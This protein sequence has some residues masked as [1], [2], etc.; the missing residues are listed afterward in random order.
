[1][2]SAGV[3]MSIFDVAFLGT[4]LTAGTGTANAGGVAKPGGLWQPELMRALLP[5]RSS[6]LRYYNFGIPGGTSVDGLAL[7]PKVAGLRP[8]VAVIEFCVNDAATAKSVSLAQS[9]AN[10]E[11]IIDAFQASWPETQVVLMTMSPVIGSAVASR[12]NLSAY[13]G[14]YRTLAASREDILLIDNE[15]SWAGVTIAEM[16]DGLHPLLSSLHARLI[17]DIVGVLGPLIS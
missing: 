7:A 16:P 9:L 11:A 2:T 4:S 14:Q 3:N 17:P 12:P 15:P 6:E 10:T 8:R 5:G 13:H 1:M